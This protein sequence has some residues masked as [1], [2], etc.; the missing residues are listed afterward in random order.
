MP[1]E[2]FADGRIEL[3][4]EEKVARLSI[5]RPEKRN[6]MSRAMWRGMVDACQSIARHPQIRVVVL[7]G[8]G[9]NFCSGADISEFSDVYASDQ[10]TESFNEDYAAAETAV[11]DLQTPV[12]A[13]IRGACYGGGLGLALAADLRFADESVQVA[14]TASKLGI[15][16]SAHDAARL[17]EKIGATHAKDM[18]F[19][20]RSVQAAEA[21]SWGLLDRVA[22]PKDLSLLVMSYA[23]D[24]VAR[25]PASLR[26][27][28]HI[29]NT[30]MEP[31]AERCMKLRPAYSEL[32]RGPD[33]VKGAKAF[34]EKREPVFD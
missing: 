15:A 8:T 14:V 9:A 22:P 3:R 4:V 2:L 34:L 10:S 28:K 13:E 19:S 31:D 29:L 16:Y 12:I 18:L 27:M 6:A 24:L 1:I 23:R 33:L 5:N 30:L 32:F 20:A 26:A 7:A 25:S 11:H 21:F 17:I